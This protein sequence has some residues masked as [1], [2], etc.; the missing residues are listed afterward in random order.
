[1]K[2]IGILPARYGST[3]L[4]GKSLK[5]ICG[6]PMIQYVY[7]VA[8]KT[9]LLTQVVVAT[10]DQRIVDAVEMF[11][12]QACLTSINHKTGTDR[13]AEVAHNV[14]ADIVVNIQGDEPLLDPRQ[15]DEVIQPM[16]DDQTLKACTLCRPIQSEED[17]KN[18]NVVK[19]VFNLQ[20][21]ALYFSRSLIPYPRITQ[22]HRAYEHIGIYVYSKDFLMQYVQMPQTPLEIS[23]SLEQL[24]IIEN[25]VRLKVVVTQFEYTGLSVDTPEDLE[26]VRKIIA[27][28]QVKG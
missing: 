27:A 16:L 3:R 18:P 22:G 6:K 24:R 28:K 2:I 7:E 12:G 9:R 21:N 15:I 11:G 20:G 13:I 8:Q 1:M 17:L 5:D 14:D 10:D 26:A 23:E 4:P 19:A 25:G